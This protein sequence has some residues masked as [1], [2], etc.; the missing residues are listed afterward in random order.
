MPNDIEQPQED[1]KKVYFD[2]RE[3]ALL[4]V[5]LEKGAK[6][7]SPTLAASMFNLFL[8]NYPCT[9]I[10]EINKGF[11][12]SDV[13]YC[14]YRFNWDDQRNQY[15]DTLQQQMLNKL[16]KIQFESLEFL[17]NTLSVLHKSE[18]DKMLTYLQT[19]KPEDKPEMWIKSI[20]GYKSIIETIQ[21]LTGE[22][23]VHKHEIKAEYRVSVASKEVTDQMPKE[24]QSSLLKQLLATKKG[25]DG[26]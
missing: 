24:V 12:E 18:R 16:K 9:K 14:R 26:K 8:E 19:G 22:D 17:T 2:D 20:A 3:W 25:K 1:P 6:P 23:K 7:I 21:K 11:T 10:A 13:L 5:V 4:S 15:A